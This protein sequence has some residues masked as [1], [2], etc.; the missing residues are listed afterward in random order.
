MIFWGATSLQRLIS[1]LGDVNA[2]GAPYNNLQKGC[3]AKIGVSANSIFWSGNNQNWQAT[4]EAPLS[5]Y[6]KIV[7]YSWRQKEGLGR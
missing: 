3:Y 1:W 4:K 6:S 5:C 7:K 2:A